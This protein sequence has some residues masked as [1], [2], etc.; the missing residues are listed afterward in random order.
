VETGDTDE[1]DD[2]QVDDCGSEFRCGDKR[3][4]GSVVQMTRQTGADE[5]CDSY[6]VV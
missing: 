6:I 4:L 1:H 3:I 5:D 2:Q